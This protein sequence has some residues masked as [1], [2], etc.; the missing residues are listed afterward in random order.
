MNAREAVVIIQKYAREYICNMFTGAT[1]CSGECPICIDD[2]VARGLKLKCGHEFHISCILKWVRLEQSCPLCRQK[3][4]IPSVEQLEKTL[5][6]YKQLLSLPVETLL[7]FESAI[8]IE[9]LINDVPKVSLSEGEKFFAMVLR[10]PYID[11]ESVYM[12]SKRLCTLNKIKRE[13]EIFDNERH[14]LNNLTTTKETTVHIMNRIRLPFEHIF[15][16][17]RNTHIELEILQEE[18][19]NIAKRIVRGRLCKLWCIERLINN[20][21]KPRWFSNS[22]PPRRIS[23][24]GPYNHVSMD[25]IE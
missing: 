14:E 4:E 25:G 8:S 17:V 24:V 3:I 15:N 16:R 23:V 10:N 11:K 12:L 2:H 19:N 7:G 21:F 13:I 5:D 22:F 6:A 1:I 20:T 18:N 9:V